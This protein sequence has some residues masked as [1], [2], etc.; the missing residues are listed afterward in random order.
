MF[1]APPLTEVS[2]LDFGPAA[3][4]AFFAV[5]RTGARCAVSGAAHRRVRAR[6]A[7][8]T[9]RG[10]S[11]TEKSHNAVKQRATRYEMLQAGRCEPGRA[12][13]HEGPRS[14]ALVWVSSQ[15]LGMALGQEAARRGLRHVAHPLARFGCDPVQGVST[16]GSVHARFLSAHANTLLIRR[17][18]DHPTR[19][20]CPVG[21]V[22]SRTTSIEIAGRGL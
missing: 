10:G 12:P 2:S 9:D 5:T 20:R 4:G 21:Q 1:L 16:A 3:R 14:V 6:H 17:I 15:E 13:L 8:S 22:K 18:F 19:I 7:P 11:I